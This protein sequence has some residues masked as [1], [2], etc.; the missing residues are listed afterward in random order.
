MYKKSEKIKI[1]KM[2]RRLRNLKNQFKSFHYH[3]LVNKVTK[4][5]M[6]KQKQYKYMIMLIPKFYIE[7]Y[8]LLYT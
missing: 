3:M 6:T 1:I 4:H 8:I 5:K 2:K 7:R